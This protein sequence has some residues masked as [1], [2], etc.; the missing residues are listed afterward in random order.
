MYDTTKKFRTFVV[1]NH[2]TYERIYRQIFRK[3]RYQSIVG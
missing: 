3:L 2:T 1:V